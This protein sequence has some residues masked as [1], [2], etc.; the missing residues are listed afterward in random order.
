MYICMHINLHMH[1]STRLATLDQW[2]MRHA[3]QTNN[4]CMCMCT[5]CVY[6]CVYMRVYMCMHTWMCMC[7][8]MHSSCS[9]SMC[10]HDVSAN[11]T[12]AYA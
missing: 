10:K 5:M 9:C 3:Q 1:I 11:G 8:A 7:I 6:M 12:C 4:M 2:H